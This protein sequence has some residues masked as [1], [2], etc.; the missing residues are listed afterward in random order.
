MAEIQTFVQFMGSALE[1]FKNIQIAERRQI[2]MKTKKDGTQEPKYGQVYVRLS[3]A[4]DQTKVV[5]YFQ[6]KV[7]EYK[8]AL[9]GGVD[10]A[11][12]A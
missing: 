2:G 9:N 6:A 7:N 1:D 10:A 5:R 4:T 11:T 3:D 8:R 12:G